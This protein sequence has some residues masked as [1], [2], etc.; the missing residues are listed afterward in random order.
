MKGFIDSIPLELEESAWL[1]GCN[2]LQ[3]L[4]RIVFPLA[5]PGVAVTGLFA[6]LGAW[7]DF[8]IPLVL[9]RSP[10]TFPIAMG[11]FRAFND[12]GNVD[13]GFL[14][15]LAVIYS[16]PSILLYL[17]ARQYLVKGMTAGSVKM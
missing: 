9:L 5:F 1:D 10:D 13:F 4:V 3:A 17:F 7:G 2:R 16:V 12:L 15:S 11:L 6:F 14:T 8:L